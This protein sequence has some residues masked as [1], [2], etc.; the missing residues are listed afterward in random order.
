M[1]DA[2]ENM[3]TEEYRRRNPSRSLE[4][5]IELMK[6]HGIKF[7]IC[8][9]QE[10]IR[11]LKRNNYF[12][13]SSYKCNYV[14]GNT[15]S[16]YANLDFAYLYD[17]SKVD[18]K[19]RKMILEL[20]I[21][22]E[23]EFKTQLKQYL[24]DNDDGYSAVSSFLS[25]QTDLSDSHRD[26]ALIDGFIKKLETPFL[27]NIVK[28]DVL[29]DPDH[30]EWFLQTCPYWIFT[31]LLDFGK[32]IDFYEFIFYPENWRKEPMEKPTSKGKNE[33]G[34]LHKIREL[35]NACA[36]NN[37]II[38]SLVPE[39]TSGKD[40]LFLTKDVQA[41]LDKKKDGDFHF[42]KNMKKVP[43]LNRLIN[44]FYWIDKIVPEKKKLEVLQVFCDDLDTITDHKDYYAG[45]DYICNAYNFLLGLTKKLLTSG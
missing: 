22:F 20:C 42:S 30:P 19:L 15:P 14:E 3:D 11:R 35:R 9:E 36:H 26:T 29:V 43:V 18:T 38:A 7:E 33:V 12:R 39:K 44:L 16:K 8:P 40:F 6:E 25:H 31:E 10:A 37:C 21:N 17:L 28:D 45:N 27:K 24:D 2:V 13:L 1:A 41:W 4:E 32:L 5:I 34:E 23:H